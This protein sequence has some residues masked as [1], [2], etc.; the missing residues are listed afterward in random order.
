M[1]QVGAEEHQWSREGYSFSQTECEVLTC[2][3]VK[4]QVTQLFGEKHSRQ[5]DQ[6]G[7][8]TGWSG[9]KFQGPQGGLAGLVA[10]GVAG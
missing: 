6:Q 9:G 10:G 8:G 2:K 3:E 7:R 4:K 1:K 5:K